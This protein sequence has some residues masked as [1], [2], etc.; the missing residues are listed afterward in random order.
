[1]LFAFSFKSNAQDSQSPQAYST[2]AEYR[3]T[4]AVAF[5][6]TLTLTKISDGIARLDWT[7]QPGIYEL[8]RTDPFGNSDTIY[9]GPVLTYLDTITSPYCESTNLSYIVEIKDISGSASNSVSGFFF[10]DNLPLDPV[11]DSISIDVL[12]HPVISWTASKSND[13]SE[14]EIQ[15]LLPSG[16]WQIIGF[17]NQ[18]LTNFTADTLD[19]CNG[20]KTFAILTVDKC[21]NRSTGEVTKKAPLN[22]IKIGSLNINECK[23][24]AILSWNAYINMKSPLGKYEIYRNENGGAF[25][26]I[27]STDQNATTYTNTNL[28]GFISGVIY[29]YKVHAISQDLTISSTSCVTSFTSARPLPPNA[30]SLNYVTVRNNQD[31]EMGLHIGPLETVKTIRVLRSDT[32]NGPFE[33]IPFSS[34]I[35]EDMVITDETAEVNQRSYYYKIEAVDN[36]DVTALT[37]VVARTIFLTCQPNP[38]ES[39]TLSWNSYEGWPIGI[40]HY[41]VYRLV[42]DLPDFANPIAIIFQGNTTYTDLP[43]AS[44]QGGDIIS[45]YV[46]AI[47]G[48]VAVPNQ[49]VS[50]TVQVIRQPQVMMPNAF[51]P[52]G[53]NKIF[54]PKML[55]VENTNFQMLIFNK[56]G[57]QIFGSSDPLMGWDGKQNGEFVPV[58][59]YFYRLEYS[60]FTGE[61]FKKSGSVIVV[62]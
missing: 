34:S 30:L 16:V 38:D 46:I 56:W 7:S 61:I 37:S 27:G 12:G 18:P 55:Y 2:I 22:T 45:Y 8:I 43:P 50:N 58:G 31:V 39:N 15:Q 19:A 10:D 23:G 29:G 42:N 40:D 1:M 44:Q 21:D 62:Q 51:A 26:L 49:S 52:K 14:Y 4:L 32:E 5:A 17:A 60:S 57:Q 13:V 3:N 35:S 20:V 53:L 47:E 11:L 36:C 48:I 59:I 28:S 54:R 33:N 6:I 24:T 9:P 25:T 41:E